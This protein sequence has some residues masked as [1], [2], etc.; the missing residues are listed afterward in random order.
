M[1]NQAD[2]CFVKNLNIFTLKQALKEKKSK[3]SRNVLAMTNNYLE[4]PPAP[5][6]IELFGHIF[7]LPPLSRH[8]ADQYW[9]CS[10]GDHLWHRG[11]VCR[12]EA[13]SRLTV[14]TSR[15][16]MAQVSPLYTLYS[17]THPVHT[18]YSGHWSPSRTSWDRQSFTRVQSSLTRCPLRRRT[19]CHLHPAAALL[20]NVPLYITVHSAPDS[21][22]HGPH[23]IMGWSM[24]TPS[25]GPTTNN[26]PSQPSNQTP[27]PLNKGIQRDHL[28]LDRRSG[29]IEN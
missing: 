14:G 29:N 1:F 2:T 24:E 28:G 12:C 15:W 23:N 26:P 20:D 11:D 18:L 19:P 9:Q 13:E 27:A 22:R 10:V 21:S 4:D 8:C 6:N 7:I 25:P 16:G 17:C 3:T 5:L